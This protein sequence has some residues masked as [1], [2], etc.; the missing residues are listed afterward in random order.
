V[1]PKRKL[2]LALLPKRKR[3]RKLQLVLLLVVGSGLAIGLVLYALSQNI[4][5]FFLPSDI[6]AGKAS[7]EQ[8]I[9]VGGMVQ[10]GSLERVN[11]S[12]KV[13]FVITD[14][15]HDLVVHYDGILPDLFREGQ[16]IVAQG[17]LQADGVFLAAEVLAKHDENYMPPEVSA[18]IQE[19]Q[20]QA[21]ASPVTAMEWPVQ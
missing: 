10:E 11:N 8:R 14:Y 2:K 12:L 20:E 15:Q 1:Y 16:A 17:R 3:K 7:L 6:V 18:A 4:N 13:G 9:R 19:A 21:N 5:L